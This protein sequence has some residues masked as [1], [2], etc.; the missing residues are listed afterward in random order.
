MH[1]SHVAPTSFQEQHFQAGAPWI[2]RTTSKANNGRPQNAR[3][4][5]AA[6]RRSMI[7]RTVARACE[8]LG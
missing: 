5:A 1:E 8:R 2:M 7:R 3:R 6:D 4:G